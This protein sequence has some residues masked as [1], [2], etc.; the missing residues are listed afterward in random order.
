MK[1]VIFALAIATSPASAADLTPEQYEEDRGYALMMYVE[2]ECV[3]KDPAKVKR[4]QDDLRLNPPP[5]TASSIDRGTRAAKNDI[6][7]GI[8][9]STLCR[10]ANVRVRDYK[11]EA[12]R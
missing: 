10:W 12:E 11:F 9:T 6:A 2:L 1:R 4:M 5:S 3:M 7:N 8:K